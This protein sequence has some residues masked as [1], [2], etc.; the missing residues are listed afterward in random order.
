MFPL[1]LYQNRGMKKIAYCVGKTIR[2]SPVIYPLFLIIQS[3][4]LA[5][6]RK[7]KFPLMSVLTRLFRSRQPRSSLDS[8][9]EAKEYFSLPLLS[10]HLTQIE[11]VAA[12]KNLVIIQESL[13]PILL[14]SF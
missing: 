12:L 9:E 14:Y 3:L 2:I 4:T 10:N 13:Y 8:Q 7:M 6:I 1:T 5:Q 11:H